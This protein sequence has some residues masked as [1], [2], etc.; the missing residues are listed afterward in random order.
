LSIQ[1]LAATTV[2]LPRSH[3]RDKAMLEHELAT[4][5]TAT[6]DGETS[7]SSRAATELEKFADV[8]STAPG[9]ALADLAPIDTVEVCTQNSCYWITVLAPDEGR[10]LVQ[11]GHFF[12][13]PSEAR[14][15]G[16][17]LGGSMLKLGWI[18]RGFCLELHIDGQCIVTS[19]IRDIR[20]RQDRRQRHGPY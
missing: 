4:N 12:P 16:S 7:E 14:L 19:V 8:A 3:R 13:T 6:T 17:S 5:T 10:V 1:H 15:A 11:G 9:V 18:G 2:S 20:L